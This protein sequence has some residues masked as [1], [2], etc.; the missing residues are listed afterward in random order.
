MRGITPKDVKREV[1]SVKGG[2][3]RHAIHS[4]VIQACDLPLVTSSFQGISLWWNTKQPTSHWSEV[5]FKEFNDDEEV[6]LLH[7]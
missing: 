3:A 2:R 7:S 4:V 1:I 6:D 5:D